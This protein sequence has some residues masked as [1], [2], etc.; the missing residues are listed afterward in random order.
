MSKILHIVTDEKFTD[1]AIRQFSA[2]EMCSEF[3]LIPSNGCMDAVKCIDQCTVIRQ[4]SKEL[5]TLLNHLGDYCAIV[6]HG[7]F[8]GG[9]QTPIMESV[10][11]NVKVAWVF[12]GGDLYSRHENKGLFYA[13]IT[14]F[15]CKLHKRKKNIQ[16]DTSWEIPLELYKRVDYC[17]TSI[18]DEYFFARDFTQ[19]T[20]PRVWYSYYSVEDTIGSLMDSQS[21]GH[22]IWIGNSAT[23]KNNHLDILWGVWKSGAWRNLKDRKIIMPLSYGAPWV[24][25]MVKKI[26]RFLFGNR[27]Q[28]LDQFIPRDEYNALM[29]SCSTMFIG[30][31]EPAATGNILTALWLGMRV[32]LSEHSMAY[33]YFKRI[34]CHVYS[35]ESDLNKNNADCFALVPDAE[36]LQNREALMTLYGKKATDQAVVDLVHLLTTDN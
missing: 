20:F 26:G 7:M 14:Q 2:P 32:Y 3:V 34:G 12:W 9:W 21:N 28:A 23:P 15:F 30:Y 36:R 11:D 10:P 31:R 29:L 5:E 22:N 13:P 16:Q 17:I 8:W 35:I 4:D 25:N 24:R 18:D 19:A 27:M 33:A 1:Y 6:L